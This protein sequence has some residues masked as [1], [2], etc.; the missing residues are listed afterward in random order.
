M[1]IIE[2]QNYKKTCETYRNDYRI[3]KIY[4]VNLETI[5]NK[6][7]QIELENNEKAKEY[8]KAWE[9]CHVLGLAEN[10]LYIKSLEQEH[11]LFDIKEGCN[12]IQF[13][14]SGGA[15][16]FPELIFG[17]TAD[18]ENSFGYGESIVNSNVAINPS[19]VFAFE[20]NEISS[21]LFGDMVYHLHKI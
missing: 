1:R 14:L 3:F 20:G 9:E 6:L 15:A 21:S 10:D 7:T 16:P 19:I 4:N 8:R 5:M 13:C 12:Y 17:L 2:S 18:I 11:I